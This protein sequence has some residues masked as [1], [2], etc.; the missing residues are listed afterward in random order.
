M[1]NRLFDHY[2]GTM[3]G[4]RGFNDAGALKLA[5]GKSVF[6]QPDAQNPDGC[7]LP[8]H[9]NARKTRRKRFPL[10]A[11][12]GACNT[13]RGTPTHLA[14]VDRGFS[15]S[16]APD[17]RHHGNGWHAEQRLAVSSDVYATRKP[18]SRSFIAAFTSA[19]TSS[20]GLVF[21]SPNSRRTRNFIATLHLAFRSSRAGIRSPR[22]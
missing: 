17:P 10:P 11:T 12:H 21:P 18:S 8:F 3:A 4:V 7:L 6:H 15:T 20:L 14:C 19:T 16:R 13:R 9:L 2:F 5:N 1:E 22:S